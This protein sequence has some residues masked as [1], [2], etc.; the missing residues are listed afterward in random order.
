[1][2]VAVGPFLI[3]KQRALAIDLRQRGRFGCCGR[4]ESEQGSKRMNERASSSSCCVVCWFLGLSV[5]HSQQQQQQTQMGLGHDNDDERDD[6]PQGHS[7]PIVSSSTSAVG[8]SIGRSA[9]LI[10]EHSLIEA[11]TNNESIKRAHEYCIVL[12]SEIFTRCLALLF[13]MTLMWSRL[14][15]CCVEQ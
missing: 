2:V 11:S 13:K 3:H 4:C 14:L 7:M 10:P 12:N 6:E 8:G 15:M 9:D 1:M 5:S